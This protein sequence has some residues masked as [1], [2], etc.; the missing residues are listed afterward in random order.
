MPVID[1]DFDVPIASIGMQLRATGFTGDQRFV[2]ARIGTGAVN[3]GEYS[4]L[5]SA[6]EARAI[7]DVFTRAADFAEPR[8]VDL[9]KAA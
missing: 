4:M 9:G 2:V 7:A 8:A 5:I 6:D 1:K 3:S